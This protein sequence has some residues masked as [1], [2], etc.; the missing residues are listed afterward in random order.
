MH[1]RNRE[2]SNISNFQNRSPELDSSFLNRL[3]QWWFTSI[4]LLGTRKNLEIDD[5]YQLN[6]SNAAA[7][8]SS[9]WE[10]L[11]NPAARGYAFLRFYILKKLL[12]SL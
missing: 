11:W 4:P 9:K 7:V 1:S 5:L 6:E 10:D 3:T 12:V 2:I 8:L